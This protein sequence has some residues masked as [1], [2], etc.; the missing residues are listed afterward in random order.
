MEPQ[1]EGIVMTDGGMFDLP[2]EGSP[3]VDRWSVMHRLRTEGGGRKSAFLKRKEELRVQMLGEG[4]PKGTA[5]E[6]A[7]R[8]AELE[9]P[10][11]PPKEEKKKKEEEKKVVEE[12]DVSGLYRDRSEEEIAC[13]LTGDILWVYD[14]L[15]KA[16]EPKDA[17]NAG[18]WSLLQWA[19]D[20]RNRFFDGL[21][22]KAAAKREVEE[23]GEDDRVVAAR[24]SL[25]ER[26]AMIKRMA[27]GT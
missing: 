2:D 14:N 21:L 9:F 18:A 13:E 22:P 8:L 4:T 12:V 15:A 16:L 17:P 25:D 1:W 27:D 26:E 19:K 23:V 20:N 24:L 10:A 3:G 5:T 11:L 6:M 7:W